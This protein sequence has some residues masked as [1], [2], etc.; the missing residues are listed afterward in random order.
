M[1][2]YKILCINVNADTSNMR[3]VSSKSLLYSGRCRMRTD[4]HGWV[5]E[6]EQCARFIK[7]TESKSELPKPVQS[8]KGIIPYLIG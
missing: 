8:I 2:Q 1:N 7:A 4:R 3:P 5:K 6:L